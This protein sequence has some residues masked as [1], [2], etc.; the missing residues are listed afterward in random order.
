MEIVTK[1]MLDEFKQDLIK[2]ISQMNTTHST[3]RKLMRN[4]DHACLC[5][6]SSELRKLFY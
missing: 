5:S 4:N 6:P 3:P 2:E 1:Q